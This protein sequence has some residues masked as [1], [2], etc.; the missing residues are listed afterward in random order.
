VRKFFQFFSL[1]MLTQGVLLLNQV[2]LLPIQIRIWGHVSTAHSYTMLAIAT[3]VG[4]A[5]CGLRT[6]GHAELIRYAHNPADEQAK[7][8]FQHLWAWIRILICVVSIT[9]IGLDL[10]YNCLYTKTPYPLWRSALVIGVASLLGA[11]IALMFVVISWTW[12][13]RSQKFSAYLLLA[14]FGSVADM[15]VAGLASYFLIVSPAIYFV[16][17]PIHRFPEYPLSRS[18]S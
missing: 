5:D 8:E 18:S 2:V 11:A 13:N 10:A 9:L 3:I 17:R 12:R 15:G 7:T 4:V 6:A 14:F 16:F 1:T